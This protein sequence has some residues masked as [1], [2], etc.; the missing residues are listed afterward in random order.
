MTEN[1]LV[2]SLRLQ[3]RDAFVAISVG[4]LLAA[5]G[6]IWGPED[7]RF[8]GVVL[9]VALTWAAFVDLD[10]F[11]LPDIITLGLVGA[12]LAMRVLKGFNALL[13]F[14]AGALLGYGLLALAAVAYRRFKGRDGLGKGDAK[15]LAAAGAWLGWTMIPTVLLVASAAALAWVAAAGLVRR[16]FVATERFAFGPFLAAAFWLVWLLGDPAAYP[17]LFALPAG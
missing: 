3:R 13:P 14:L 6:L 2:R 8:W 11:I 17:D 12:G 1:F 5:L 15:L 9:A 7:H 16:R 10:R 4:V